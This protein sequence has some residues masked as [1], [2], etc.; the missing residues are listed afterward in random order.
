MLFKGNKFTWLSSY[1]YSIDEKTGEFKKNAVAQ[2]ATKD[3]AVELVTVK[4]R[5]PVT[6]LSR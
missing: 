4:K 5:V 1:N 2:P 3:E 6:R